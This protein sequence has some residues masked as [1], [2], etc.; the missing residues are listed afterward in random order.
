M[1]WLITFYC[2]C[3]LCCG[4]WAR[5]G[6]TRSGTRPEAYRT[7]ACDP[8]LRGRVV[9]LLGGALRFRCEDTGSKVRGRR[10]DIYVGAGPGKHAEARRRG[11]ARV[12]AQIDRWGGNE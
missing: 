8:R 7:A 4:P 11:V 5:Y 10:L 12:K 1:T 3:A 2:A 9:S 6:L